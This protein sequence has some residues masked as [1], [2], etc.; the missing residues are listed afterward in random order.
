MSSPSEASAHADVE[1]AGLIDEIGATI[2]AHARLEQDA[3]PYLRLLASSSYA[4]QQCEQL[5]LAAV[6]Q[7]RR[8]GHSWSAVGA[9]LGITRQAAQ[10]RFGTAP[11]DAPD[12]PDLKRISGTS[13]F[14][15]MAILA[16]EGA[17]GYHLVDFGVLYLELKASDAVWE[18]RRE[19]AS[20]I[21]AKKMRLGAAGWSYVGAWFPFHY[22]KRQ[23]AA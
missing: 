15:E 5:Q 14:N 6:Q 18:H 23:R 22:F 4:V 9:V 12:A 1:H 20:G 17:A 2:L 11:S 7:A 19:L 10:Q 21:R 3:D 16:S 13:A 8:A